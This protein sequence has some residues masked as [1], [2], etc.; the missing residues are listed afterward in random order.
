MR[1]E[2]KVGIQG[3]TCRA[4]EIDFTRLVSNYIIIT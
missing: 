3:F 4:F 1:L 2:I